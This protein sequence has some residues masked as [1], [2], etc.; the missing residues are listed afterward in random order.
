MPSKTI[1]FASIVIIPEKFAT[2]SLPSDMTGQAKSRYTNGIVL[3]GEHWEEFKNPKT[4]DHY[5]VYWQLYVN[6][7]CTEGLLVIYVASK[8]D[9]TTVL[10][11][12]Q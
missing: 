4:V 3:V 1:E 2:H 10:W 8:G 11:R 6:T 9:L 12:L 7:R 5:Q